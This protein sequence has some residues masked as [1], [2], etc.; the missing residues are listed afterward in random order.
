[1]ILGILIKYR[2]WIGYGLAVAALAFSV[3]YIHNEGYKACEEDALVKSVEVSEKRNEIANNRP[4][5]NT[6]LN[7]LLQDDNW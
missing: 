4:D 7:G 3:W 1:M 6:F 5:T 2:H